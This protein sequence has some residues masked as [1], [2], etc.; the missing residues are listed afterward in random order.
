MIEIQDIRREF[1]LSIG[2]AFL[3]AGLCVL[4]LSVYVSIFLMVFSVGFFFGKMGVQVDKKSG[5]YRAFT[6][7]WFTD[8]GKWRRI[9]PQ[10]TLKLSLS[11][12]NS[13]MK[14]G[15]MENVLIASSKSIYYLLTVRGKD[16]QEDIMRF[17]S[18]R[19]ARKTMDALNKNFQLD[20][21]D[22]IAQK[23]AENRQRRGSR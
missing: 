2:A 8:F 20:F 17:R 13:H 22:E 16:G 1:F 14:M 11:A 6:N 5:H 7:I 10:D 15:G 23:I 12:N 18:Y 19:R 9:K 3:I 4:G 21:L